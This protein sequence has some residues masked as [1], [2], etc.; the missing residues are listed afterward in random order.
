MALVTS[1]STL[2]T[3][4][5]DTLWRSSLTS[6]IKN[7][8]QQFEAGAQDDFRL[9]KLMDRG[10]VTVSADGLAMP[11]D[12][13]S[14]DSWYHAGPTYYGRINIVGANDVGGPTGVP[15]SAAIVNGVARFG[16]PPDGT[17]AT[18]MTYWAKVTAL[19]DAAPTNWLLLERPD[20]YVY[21]SLLEA[22]PFLKDDIR[23]STWQTALDRQ[24]EAFA[25]AQQDARSGSGMRRQFT[26]I[27]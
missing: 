27:G 17:Y 19:S 18:K 15:G 16:P 12:Y 21:G 20:I 10:T 1:Y 3:H 13:Y 11:S 14:L 7:F 2:Q 22:A 4:V 25:Q 26:P 5:A 23:I 8:I 6:Q 9:R 24:I